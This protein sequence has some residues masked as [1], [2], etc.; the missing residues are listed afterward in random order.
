VGGDGR[1]EGLSQEDWH[2]IYPQGEAIQ[3]A[4]Y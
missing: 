3:A 1:R 2:P 4:A